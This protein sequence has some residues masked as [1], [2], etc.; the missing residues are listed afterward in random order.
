LSTLFLAWYI[1]VCKNW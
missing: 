1:I